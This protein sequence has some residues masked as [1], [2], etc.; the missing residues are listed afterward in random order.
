MEWH[1]GVNLP[2][3]PTL[4]PEVSLTH[5]I[6]R[7]FCPKY[8][9]FTTRL[10]AYFRPT[11]V[12]LASQSFWLD[13]LLVFMD[14]SHLTCMNWYRTRWYV[15]VVVAHVTPVLDSFT[16]SLHSPDH[17][18]KGCQWPLKNGGNY[19]RSHESTMHSGLPRIHCT[20]GFPQSTFGPANRKSDDA[21]QWETVSQTKRKYYSHQIWT[22]KQSSPV[23]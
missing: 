14:I 22:V 18:R 17:C 1:L 10:S 11:R 12:N 13:M 19:H 4:W 7:N 9:Y 15:V 20:W 3:F 6:P 2:N 21:S 23:W 5:C 8:R 16:A